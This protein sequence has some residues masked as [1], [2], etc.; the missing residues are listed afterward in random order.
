MGISGIE[1]GRGGV[2][3]H[4][5]GEEVGD[6]VEKV[7]EGPGPGSVASMAVLAGLAGSSLVQSALLAVSWK[8]QRPGILGDGQPAEDA[9]GKGGLH[10]G[11]S[12]L[13]LPS[14]NGVEEVARAGVGRVP[15]YLNQGN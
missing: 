8:V 2:V 9:P 14:G 1:L 5:G 3:W 15:Q 7:G 6:G 11:V 13:G 10:A 4:V 12:I